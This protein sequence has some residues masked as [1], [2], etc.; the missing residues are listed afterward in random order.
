VDELIKRHGDKAT[1]SRLA[2]T[3]VESNT[4]CATISA[5]QLLANQLKHG[6]LQSV[7]VSMGDWQNA[8]ARNLVFGSSIS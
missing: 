8:A 5:L 3:V 2:L 1:R 7:N 4:V 6:P